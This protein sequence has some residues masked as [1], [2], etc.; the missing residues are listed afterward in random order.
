M[1]Q[2]LLYLFL[3]IGIGAIGQTTINVTSAGAVGDNSTDNT[4]FIQQAINTVSSSGG[5]EVI[6]DG[7]TFL[8]STLNIKSNVTLRITTGTTLKAL[9]NNSD[10]PDIPYSE[11]SWS[12]TYTQKSLLFAEAAHNIRIT[13]GGT[14]DG[15]GLQTGY[16]SVSK[17]YRP[18]GLRL[19]LVDSLVID[20]INLRQ[21]PQ[22][23]G[24][25]THCSHVYINHITVYNQGFGSNDGIDIDGCTDV[26]VENSQF[27]TNDDPLPVKTHGFNI[28]RDVLIRNC[29]FATFERAVK[30]GNEAMGPMVNIRFKDITVNASSFNLPFTPQNVIYCAIADG[31]SMDSIYF[32]NIQINTPSEFAIFLRLCDR[33]NHY[34][35]FPHPP[36]QFLRNVWFKNIKCRT[37]KTIPC[38]VTGIPGYRPENIHFENVEITVPGNGPAV[39]GNVPELEQTRPE[40]DQWGDSLP[41]YGLYV[42]HIK[43][44]YLD[45]FCVI[46]QNADVRPLYYFEDTLAVEAN[47]C[48]GFV[49][50]VS[51]PQAQTFSLYPN[52]AGNTV[53]VNFTEPVSLLSLYN[54]SGQLLVNLPVNNKSTAQ[55]DVA[56]LQPGIYLLK[57]NSQTGTQITRLVVSH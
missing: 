12:D 35:T 7:G 49:S 20:S 4:L 19:H 15:N 21:A 55:L 6:F 30:V 11:R 54:L 36:V 18:F 51:E 25:I 28:C 45:N 23:M 34:D 47:E 16:L 38:S 24:H 32:E 41:A 1:R 22:W 26:L 10:F 56:N 17:N 50:S 3:I 2:F 52:P 27:D 44:L 48:T 46:K 14:I 29:T 8:S 53:Y 57:A 13:G 40:G 43:N 31:G 33:G 39:T 9:P 5:G 37:T 42:R